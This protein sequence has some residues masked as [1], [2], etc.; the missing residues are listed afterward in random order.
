MTLRFVGTAVNQHQGIKDKVREDLGITLEYIAVTSDD[1]VR[2][3][4][5]QPNSF[6]LMDLEF[7]MARRVVPTGNLVGLEAKRIKLA[8]EITPAMTRGEVG[9]RKIGAQGLAPL[10]DHLP[11]R[12]RVQE[13][14]RRPD[15]VAD[16]HSRPSTTPTRSASARTASTAPSSPGPSC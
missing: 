4:V 15:R 11:R 14:R 6:D 7:W 8:D 5:T 16:H 2:R 3:A 1:V 9:G 10:E 13:L 12:P